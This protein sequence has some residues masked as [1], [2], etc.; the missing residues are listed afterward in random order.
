MRFS[1]TDRLGDQAAPPG[2][3]APPKITTHDPGALRILKLLEDSPALTDAMT[4]LT[5]AV[6]NSSQINHTKVLGALQNL[7]DQ[8]RKVSTQIGLVHCETQN[9][10]SGQ[11]LAIISLRLGEQACGYL[12]AGLATTDPEKIKTDLAQAVTYAQ[13][14]QNDGTHAIKRLSQ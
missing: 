12:H 14:S 7:I 11:Q 1:R 6:P 8:T 3:N 10:R 5:A 9:G 13:A 2:S 4:A